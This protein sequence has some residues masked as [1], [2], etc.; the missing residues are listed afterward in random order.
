MPD[1]GP[2]APDRESREALKR[3]AAEV[4]DA[5]LGPLLGI[6]RRL[7]QSPGDRL[8]GARLVGVPGR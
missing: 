5:R 6:S 8:A 2:R 1:R 4:V 7:H 3:R